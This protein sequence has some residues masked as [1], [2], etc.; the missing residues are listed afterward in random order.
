ME[1]LHKSHPLQLEWGMTV[2]RECGQACPNGH[3]VPPEVNPT[4]Q[5]GKQLVQ[6]GGGM[7]SRKG[8]EITVFIFVFFF[9]LSWAN[10]L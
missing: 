1:L 4:F 5:T 7:P 3:M 8:G 2:R 6:K 10:V 9:F